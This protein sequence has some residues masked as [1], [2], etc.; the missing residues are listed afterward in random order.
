VSGHHDELS[1]GLRARDL[2]SVVLLLAGGALLR[3]ALTGRYT[4]YVK[5]SARPYL[6]AAGVVI[7]ALA[8][9]SLWQTV[10]ARRRHPSAASW[11][12]DDDGHDHRRGRVE[13]AWLLVLPLA[14][15]LLIAPK[16][17]GAYEAGRAGSAL[18]PAPS[19][20][21]GPL[22]AGDPVRLSVVGYATRAVFDAGRTLAGHHVQLTGF[23]TA[24]PGGGWYLTRML[25]TCCAADAQ[26]IKVGLVGDLPAGLAADGWLTVI[27]GYTSQT[28]KDPVNG[29]TIPYLAV[30]S[31]QVTTQPADP[32]ES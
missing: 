11:N 1:G 15:L 23:L 16:P 3:I 13:V 6:T 12:T 20:P 31:A 26:P 28:A 10:A 19:S 27:G 22:P 18:P 9:V 21:Y 24:A 29:A 4:S 8:L 30:T 5:A 32:Y 17:A 14:V 2:H 7:T 25:V